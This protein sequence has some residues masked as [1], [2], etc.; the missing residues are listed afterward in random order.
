MLSPARRWAID[1]AGSTMILMPVAVLVVLLLGAIAF[2]LSWVYEAQ[3]EAIDAA[4]SAADDAA[5][6]GVIPSDIQAGA[7]VHLDPSRIERAVDRSLSGPHLRGFEPERT[8]VTTD[9]ATGEITVTIT[10]H[11]EYLF[12]KAIPGSNH[13][14]EVTAS[15]TATIE[16]R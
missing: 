2:D 1:D 14:R 12:A 13:G 11:V 8:T 7:G 9:A 15:G 3:H 5:T 4:E 16:Q 10:C 6:Y